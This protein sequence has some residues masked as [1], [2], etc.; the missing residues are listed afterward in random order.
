M[1]TPSRF[2]RNGQVIGLHDLDEL[3]ALVKAGIL[4]RE[5][6]YWNETTTDWKPVGMELE[7]RKRTRLKK[8]VKI[9]GASLVVLAA[10]GFGYSSYTTAQEAKAREALAREI[11][12]REAAE[13][14]RIMQLK[15]DKA[16][17]A[18][19]Y[20][21]KT[22]TE[23]LI[24]SKFTKHFNKYSKVQTYFPNVFL[25]K[26]NEATIDHGRLANQGGMKFS[27]SP[28]IIFFVSENGRLEMYSSYYGDKWLFHVAV[29]S[30]NEKGHFKTPQASPSNITR[31]TDD[32]SVSERIAFD[33]E[34]S[35]RFLRELAKSKE[36]NPQLDFLDKDGEAVGMFFKM[37]TDY[38][39]AVK[40]TVT[41]ADS[42]NS[43]E[44]LKGE[45]INAL[46]RQAEAGDAEAQYRL[47]KLIT[48]QDA[49]LKWLKASSEKE[50]WPALLDYADAIKEENPKLSEEL[51]KKGHELAKKRGIDFSR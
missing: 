27:K 3:E 10:L 36:A 11:R 34:T 22:A 28:A 46:S 16:T 44:I 35:E 51:R 26:Y 29:E 17:V 9:A 41:L 31:K 14:A 38:I 24:S 18:R 19:F 43:L 49:Q 42:F 7:K 20:E 2:A 37:G 13:E 48:D 50:F 47:S 25:G 30:R 6:Y 4:Q 39:A 1:P 33:Y 23:Q 15:N 21:T 40:D 45:A 12:L 5:D 32:D 8:A